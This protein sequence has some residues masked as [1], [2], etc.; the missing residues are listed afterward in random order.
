MLPFKQS[1]V[2]SSRAAEM[3]RAYAAGVGCTL[4]GVE[5]LDIEGS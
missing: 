2:D 4:T 3:D 1:E 5:V